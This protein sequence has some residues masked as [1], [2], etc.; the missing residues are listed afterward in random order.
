M[1]YGKLALTKIED[2]QYYIQN[3]K[4]NNKINTLQIEPNINE[5]FINYYSYSD[6][7]KALSQDFVTI[8]ITFIIDNPT[9]AECLIKAYLN[10]AEIDSKNIVIG[11]GIGQYL[12][13]FMAKT[14]EE[15]NNIKFEINFTDNISRTIKNLSLRISGNIQSATNSNKIVV[16]KENTYTKVAYNDKDFIYYCYLFGENLQLSK[17]FF[18]RGDYTF[19][20]CKHNTEN[21]EYDIIFYYLDEGKLFMHVIPYYSVFESYKILIDENVTSVCSAVCENPCGCILYYLKG[22]NV[23]YLVAEKN[24]ND[25]LVLPSKS[26]IATSSMTANKVFAVK[27]QNVCGFILNEKNSNN[28][29]Y[30]YKGN[31]YNAEKDTVNANILA[32]IEDLL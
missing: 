29:M 20:A 7:F 11:S 30:L 13:R 2:I 28:T 15:D 23:Y 10:T 25:G 17:R 8:D 6:N 18:Y 3:L 4:S 19:S 22:G 32:Y 9:S 16:S 31:F 21:Y 14:Q 5:T 26:K 1:D 12:I 27:G 24:Q